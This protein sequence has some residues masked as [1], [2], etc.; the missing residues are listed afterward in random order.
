M[1]LDI[2]IPI[3]NE[4]DILQELHRRLCE[5]CDSL[6]SIGWQVIYINDGSSDDSMKIL[7]EQCQN[8]TRISIIEL[9]RN[10]GHQAAITVGLAHADGDA[11]VIMDGDLQDPPEL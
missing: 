9:S 11:V 1:K 10:F 2:V 4:Q 3:Y 6:D 5:V 7:L 8:D